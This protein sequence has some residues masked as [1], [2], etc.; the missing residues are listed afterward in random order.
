MINKGNAHLRLLGTVWSDNTGSNQLGYVIIDTREQLP[1]MTTLTV[2]QLHNLLATTPFENAR[3]E[4][5]AVVSTECSLDRLPKYNQQGV[6]FANEGYMIVGRIT[7]ERGET[8]GFR[9]VTSRGEILNV[10]SETL[11]KQVETSNIFLINAKVVTRNNNLHISAIRNEFKVFE[12]S[13]TLSRPAEDYDAEETSSP[14]RTNTPEAHA[15]Y[16]RKLISKVATS[17]LEKG[18]PALRSPNTK[19]YRIF[20]KEFLKPR[21]PELAQYARHDIGW[22]QI[23]ATMLLLSEGVKVP[24]YSG[25]YITNKPLSISKKEIKVVAKVGSSDRNPSKEDVFFKRGMLNRVSEQLIDI[26]AAYDAT[27]DVVN[28]LELYNMVYD[29]T[30]PDGH[31]V[32]QLTEVFYG[33]IENESI[34]TFVMN[35]INEKIN[36]PVRRKVEHF[37]YTTDELDYFSEAGVEQL[38]LTL[39]PERDGLRIESPLLKPIRTTGKITR[40]GMPLRYVFEGIDLTDEQ[41]EKLKELGNCYGDFNIFRMLADIQQELETPTYSGERYRERLEVRA[42]VLINF[43]VYI[44]AVHNR[45]FAKEVVLYLGLTPQ[46]LFDIDSVYQ[47]T[48]RSDKIFYHSGLRFGTKATL[49]RGASFSS[50]KTNYTPKQTFNGFTSLMSKV[51]PSYTLPSNYIPRLTNLNCNWQY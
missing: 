6:I 2:H 31:P 17:G 40:G 38:G 47:A 50:A 21:Y 12:M 30:T 1:R 27:G 29:G 37:M 20:H 14:G 16:L 11:L 36:P 5:G 49:V 15:G 51:A 10:T 8:R 13:S 32:R 45:Y 7:D 39:D 28:A 41:I 25:G 34:K 46:V 18:Q 4:N 44:L 48:N 43:Y 3:L 42:P 24:K 35:L 22:V 19:D 33:V 9:L 26:V 23:I